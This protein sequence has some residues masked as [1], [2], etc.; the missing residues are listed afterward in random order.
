MWCAELSIVCLSACLVC[1]LSIFQPLILRSCIFNN[2]S[3]TANTYVSI[4]ANTFSNNWISI[5]IWICDSRPWQGSVCLPVSIYRQL[6]IRFND[7]ICVD[8]RVMESRFSHWWFTIA[9]LT[10]P[11]IFIHYYYDKHTFMSVHFIIFMISFSTDQRYLV[12]P[13]QHHLS[14][15]QPLHSHHP[16]SQPFVVPW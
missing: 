15:H 1:L 5:W 4:T 3:I 6:I 16:I 9:M 11:C 7:D 14:H 12:T 10:R 2:E 13:H 8:S